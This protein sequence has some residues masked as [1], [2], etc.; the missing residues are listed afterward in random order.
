M[1]KC[2]SD[3]YMLPDIYINVGTY[4]WTPITPHHIG[5]H[6][7]RMTKLKYVMPQWSL[8]TFIYLFLF[9]SKETIMFTTFFSFLKYASPSLI[10]NI[11]FLFS[12][13]SPVWSSDLDVQTVTWETSG[14]TWGTLVHVWVDHW[15]GFPHIKKQQKSNH[16]VQ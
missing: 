12:I 13:P 4:W 14:F 5:L 2:S 8:N 15:A 7:V 6:K 11:P 9:P 1:S 16:I 10:P 3:N